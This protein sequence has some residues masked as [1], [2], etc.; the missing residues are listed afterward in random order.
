MQKEKTIQELTFDEFIDYYSRFVLFNYQAFIQILENI[1]SELGYK[2]INNIA[3][4]FQNLTVLQRIEPY[5]IVKT[6]DIMYIFRKVDCVCV[7]SILNTTIFNNIS[8][9]Y[10]HLGIS[11]EHFQFTVPRIKTFLTVPGECTECIFSVETTAKIYN[12]SISVNVF[13]NIF[14]NLATLF[15]KY[16]IKDEK[17]KQF[18]KEWLQL[19]K[20]TKLTKTELKK[21]EIYFKY[22]E[23]IKEPKGKFK[24]RRFFDIPSTRDLK[25]KFFDIVKSVITKENVTY[26]VK[27]EELMKWYIITILTMIENLR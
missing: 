1:C 14:K 26:A 19:R 25:T 13:Q 23:E 12:T 24:V 16:V 22:V 20:I 6:I 21:R 8:D 10:L 4:V 7:V 3:A 27:E 18:I 17:V 9:G 15:N 5:Y 2:C 11:L